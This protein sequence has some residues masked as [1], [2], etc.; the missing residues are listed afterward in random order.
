MMHIQLFQFEVALGDFEQNKDKIK[1]LFKEKLVETTNIVVLPEMWNNGYDLENLNYKADDNLKLTKEFISKLAQQYSVHIVAGSV[2]NKKQGD[3]YNTLVVFNNRG[4]LIYDYDKIHLVPML[5]EPKFMTGGHSLSRPFQLMDTTMGAVIC[6]DLRF[7]E[8]IRGMAV[9]GAQVIFVVAQWP[10]AR[11]YHWRH[12]NI[13]RA[14]ENDAYV[15]ACNSC[16]N[17][18]KTTYAGH[19]MIIDPSGEVIKE[20]GESESTIFKEVD[21]ARVQEMR[22]SIPVFKNRR[23]DLYS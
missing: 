13:A 2:S 19:S 3:V 17:D 7:P 14:I 5:D 21:V 16:G 10:E 4:E 22:E 1:Q 15:I 18:T 9:K 6:Y 23:I 20:A 11:L 8:S 12:L